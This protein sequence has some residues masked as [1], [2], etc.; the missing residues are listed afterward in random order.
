MNLGKVLPIIARTAR[1]GLLC[2]LVRKEDKG[3]PCSSLR[4]SLE[5]RI[6][7]AKL[8]FNHNNVLVTFGF[9]LKQNYSFTYVLNSSAGDI[10]QNGWSLVRILWGIIY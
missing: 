5:G 2:Y 8:S 10:F 6:R 7:N 3:T 1:L 4:N 9:S